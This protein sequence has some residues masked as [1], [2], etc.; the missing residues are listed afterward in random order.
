[1][2]FK[3]G[4]LLK[5]TSFKDHLGEEKLKKLINFIPHLYRQLGHSYQARHFC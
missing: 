3:A 1:M 4:V 5:A 2:A